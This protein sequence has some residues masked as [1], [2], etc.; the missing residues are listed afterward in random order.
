MNVREQLEELRREKTPH[1]A[2][3]MSRMAWERYAQLKEQ[4]EL[5]HRDEYVMIEVDSGDYFLGKTSNEALRDAQDAYPEKAFFLI[6]IGH[7][8]AVK[9]R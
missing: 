1:N 7:R 8:A 9:R 2:E 4:L 5:S 3:E 6:R